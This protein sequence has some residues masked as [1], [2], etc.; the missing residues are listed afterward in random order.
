MP[1]MLMDYDVMV[2]GCIKGHVLVRL[3]MVF[4]YRVNHFS[5]NFMSFVQKVSQPCDLFASPTLK[6]VLSS[7]S[8]SPELLKRLKTN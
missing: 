4:D 6:P 8:F 2:K 3:A 7:A 5:W 1:F